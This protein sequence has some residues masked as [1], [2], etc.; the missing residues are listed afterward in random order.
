MTR[1][2]LYVLEKYGKW[3]SMDD[4]RYELGFNPDVAMN[5]VYEGANIISCVSHK[6]KGMTTKN[7][8]YLPLYSHGDYRDDC[9]NFKTLARLIRLN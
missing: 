9:L 3:V 7:K 4:C 6:Y 5:A 1:L 2:E 8:Y